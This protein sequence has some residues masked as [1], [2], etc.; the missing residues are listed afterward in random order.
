MKKD[1]FVPFFINLK[2]KKV[3]VIGGGKIAYRKVK[4]LLK[5]EAEVNIVTK[6][7]EQAVFDDLVKNKDINLKIETLCQEYTALEGQLRELDVAKYFMVVAATNCKKLNSF[8]SKYCDKQNILVNNVTSQEE[9]N[10]RFCKYLEEKNFKIGIS[11]NGDPNIAKGLE[12]KL[13]S[14]IRN[15]Y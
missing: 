3:L 12:E 14:L 4:A 6:K 13:I 8:I 11:G 1:N 15:E 10:V 2:S 5:Y 9:M 7:I